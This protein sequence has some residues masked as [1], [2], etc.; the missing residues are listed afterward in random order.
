MY[1]V[2]KSYS[3]LVYDS[4]GQFPVELSCMGVS[5]DGNAL[6]STSN[7]HILKLYVRTH[8]ELQHT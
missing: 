2:L 4:K 3:S 6:S 7:V 5:M 1:V 8:P